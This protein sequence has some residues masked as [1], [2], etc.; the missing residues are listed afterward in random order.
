M[1]FS[2]RRWTSSAQGEIHSEEEAKLMAIISEVLAGRYPLETP[3]ADGKNR[4][5]QLLTSACCETDVE[6]HQAGNISKAVLPA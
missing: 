1:V 3:D 6:N 4:M 5:E 2:I